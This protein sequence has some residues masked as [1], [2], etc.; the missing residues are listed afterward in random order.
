MGVSPFFGDVC[1]LGLGVTGRAVADYFLLNPSC[2]NS[3]TI[4]PGNVQGESLE[5]LE[6]LPREVVVRS[7]EDMVS[8]FYDLTVVS[9]GIPPHANL[10]RSAQHASREVI[11]EPEL[12]WRISPEHWI[13][14]TGTNGKTTVTELTAAL[15][16]A[17]GKTAWAAGNIGVPCI[18][19]IA[20]RSPGD[21]LVA[22]LSSYQL[23]SI[24]ELAPEVAVLLNITPDHLNWHGSHEDYSADK[25]RIFANLAPD[26]PVILD[27]SL[28]DVRV[29]ADA[30]AHA[31]V[32]VIRVDSETTPASTAEEQQQEAA[33]IDSAT[34][35]LTLKLTQGEY[36]L[37][38]TDELKI[39]GPHNIS[40]ALAAAAAVCLAVPDASKADLA[41][42]L[43]AF[44]PLAHRF[45]PCGEV[46]GVYFI[47]DSKA[48]NSDAAIKALLAFADDEQKGTVT[49]LFGGRDKGTCLDDLVD[50]CAQTCRYAVCYGEAGG[51]FY[52]ALSSRV[53]AVHVQS[54]DEAFAR[55]FELAR[56]GDTVLLSPAC[57]SFDEFASFEARGD[58][59]K[60]L[61]TRLRG[62][63]L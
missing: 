40:N 1:L 4:Y 27:V 3:L 23:H 2:L 29:I 30:A 42:G 55:A 18:K 53:S 56:I 26:K 63:S 51:R 47:N 25:Q 36:P 28:P 46:S 39:K 32:R 44:S 37:L 57:A 31:G 20:M 21:W 49:A 7:G 62:E 15:L 35:S 43:A 9:P 22:E 59:F 54:F 60:T 33:F 16:G 34:Q 52:E 12:A 50:A 17:V 24:V 14:I 58:Y 13:A 45:E 11:S 48:T 6:Q 5:Y 10:Y 61:V 41:A 8:G 38:R 19:A